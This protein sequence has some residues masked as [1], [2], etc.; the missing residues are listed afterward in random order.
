MKRRLA[1]VSAAATCVVAAGLA[2]CALWGRPRNVQLSQERLQSIIERQFPRQQR[3]LEVIDIDVARPKL[4]LLPERNRIGTDLDLI[5]VERLT[6]RTVRGSLTLNYALRYEASDASLRMSQ[7]RV[8]GLTL[9]LG[10][11]SLPSEAAR[12]GALLAERLLDDFVLYRA[13]A[14]HLKQLQR[15][16]VTA[17]AVVVTSGGIELR[18]AEP[19]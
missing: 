3:L 16:G 14:E 11:G 19:R 12:L 2:G 10:S 18:F 8:E 5:A 17:A 6:G 4:R 9:D 1:V 7:V 15:A 13:D